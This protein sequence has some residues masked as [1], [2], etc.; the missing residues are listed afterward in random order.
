MKNTSKQIAE[1]SI[2]TAIAFIFSYIESLFP[3]PIPFPGIKLGLANLA[4]V[5]VLYRHGFI[6]AFSVSMIRNLL[7][8]FTFGSL[9][10]FLY[11]LVGSIASLFI[12]FLLKKI[13]HPHISVIG[14]SCVGGI[15]HNIGQFAVASCLVGLTAI[16]PYLPFLYFSGLIA[17]ILIGVFALFCQNRLPKLAKPNNKS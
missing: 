12:M 3:L 4:V 17:G 8:A 9:F 2:Y 10:G 5:L 14:V 15:I 16:L 1:L 13:K 6:S 7:N 11:S